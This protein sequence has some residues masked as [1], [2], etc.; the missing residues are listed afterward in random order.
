MVLYFTPTGN[1]ELLRPF[2]FPTSTITCRRTVQFTC[3]RTVDASTPQLHV[4]H[5]TITCRHTVDG[6]NY[7]QLHVEH[8]PQLRVDTQYNYT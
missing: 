3:R 2:E 8:K 5:G 7:I 1:N 4:E 6:Y